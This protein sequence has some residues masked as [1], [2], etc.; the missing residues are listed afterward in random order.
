MLK[1][2]KNNPFGVSLLCGFAAESLIVF[3]NKVFG[4]YKIGI[5]FLVSVCLSFGEKKLNRGENTRFTTFFCRPLLLSHF[6]VSLCAYSYHS[7]VISMIEAAEEKRSS[8]N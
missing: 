4:K 5:L 3:S 8:L 6:R 7:L 1:G 2:K